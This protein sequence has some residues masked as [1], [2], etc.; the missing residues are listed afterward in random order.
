MSASLV[1]S[2]MCIR[3][4]TPHT[5]HPGPRTGPPPDA[6]RGRRADLTQGR[7][8]RTQPRSLQCPEASTTLAA[9]A[10]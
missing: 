7:N 10:F 8:G 1:G 2:E 4:R 6:S 3:D 5:T 9:S